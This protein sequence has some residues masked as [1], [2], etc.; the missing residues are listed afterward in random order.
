VTGATVYIRSATVNDI[1]LILQF[2]R[3]KAEFDGCP[4]SVEA[5]ADKLRA[6]LFG[7]IPLA[8]VLF[9]EIGGETV[10]FAAYFTTFST[11]LARPGIWL[12]DLFV[13]ASM[14]SQGI[15][16]ALLTHLAKLAQANGCGRIEWTASVHNDRGMAFYE[17]HGARIRSNT[18][19]L[20]MDRQA[21]ER[22]AH[23]DS[24]SV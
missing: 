2:I 9:A 22:M 12:D 8:G 15:G 20:R 16:K 13:D 7:D 11:F 21:I 4:E 3:K 17:R 14:R 5:T 18:R 6:T 24:A 19:L 1:P 10:G 23:N